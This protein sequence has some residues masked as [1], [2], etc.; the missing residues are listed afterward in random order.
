MFR[1]SS[2]SAGQERERSRLTKDRL[3]DRRLLFINRQICALSA[4]VI[5]FMALYVDSIYQLLKTGGGAY[6]AG[7]F[8]PLLLGCFWKRADARMINIGMLTG[9]G[10]AFFFDMVLKIPLGLNIDGVTIGAL[11]CLLICVGG[12]LL[13]TKKTNCVNPD[14]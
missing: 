7:V 2:S 3:D 5:C 11:L 12:S 8:F 4:V 14:L 6:G 1:S 9:T 10:V 13:V